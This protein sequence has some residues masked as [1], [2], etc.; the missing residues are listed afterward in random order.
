LRKI[1]EQCCPLA[2]KQS[3]AVSASIFPAELNRI[4]IFYTDLHKYI[5][6]LFTGFNFLIDRP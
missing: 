6:L 2:L 3:L 5:I 1:P 4:E